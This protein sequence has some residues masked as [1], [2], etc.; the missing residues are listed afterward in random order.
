MNSKVFAL[1]GK[2]HRAGKHRNT[3]CEI[4]M[5]AV[6]KCVCIFFLPV[7]ALFIWESTAYKIFLSSMLAAV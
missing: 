5:N 7:A 4:L 6:P 1:L 3:M 2:A